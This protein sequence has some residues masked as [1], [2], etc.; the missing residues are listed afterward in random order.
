MSRST[1]RLIVAIAS[2]NHGAVSRSELLAAGLSASSIDRRV[3]ELLE[4]FASGVYLVGASTS[5]T[6]LSA[7]LL[8]EP[9]AAAADRTAA[10]M[11]QLPVHDVDAVSIVVPECV[12]RAFP[13]PVSSRRTRHLPADDV[14]LIA[15]RRVT[16]VERT[17]CDLSIVVSV[18]QLQRLI[19]W[20]ITNRRMTASSFRACAAAFCRRGRRGSARLRLLRHELLDGAAVPASELERRGRELLDRHGI[21]G[22]SLQFVPPWSDGLRGIVD[23]AWPDAHMILELD[24]RRWHALTEAQSL[25]RRRDRQAAEAGWLVV[26]TTWDEVVH[27]PDSIVADLRSLLTQRRSAALSPQ[28]RRWSAAER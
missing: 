1:D 22:Y 17:V 12:R 13:A 21:S 19:E 18:R 5:A 11:L 8:T 25:D 27:R 6:Q 20:S 7:A 3:G 28:N 16:T 2:A 26:R 9:R 23:V 10:Q 14:D 15:G 24:G 4:L